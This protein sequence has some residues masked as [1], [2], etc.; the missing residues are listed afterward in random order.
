MDITYLAIQIALLIGILE[1]IKQAFLNDEH[2]RF[3]PL[4]A[5]VLGVA[6]STLLFPADTMQQSVIDGLIAA[7]SSVG[8]FSTVKN[9][10]K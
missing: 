4:I 6:V 8:L 3:I 2:K 1:V 9:T 10:V 7:L 5:L